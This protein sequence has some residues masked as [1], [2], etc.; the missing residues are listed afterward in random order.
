MKKILLIVVLL[1]FIPVGA[2]EA[3]FLELKSG[4]N[5][6]IKSYNLE[7]KDININNK[8]DEDEYYMLHPMEYVKEEFREMYFN[9]KTR[10]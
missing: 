8:R 7:V 6:E 9:K 2:E 3:V 5:L 10:D 4:Q 1:L